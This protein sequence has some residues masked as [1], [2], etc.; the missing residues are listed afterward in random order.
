M[1]ESKRIEV[2]I[3]NQIAHVKLARPNKHNA[4]DM[5]MFDSIVKTIK[6]LKKDRSIRVVIL[7]GQ[8]PDFCTGL[9]VKS[10]MKSVKGPLKLLLKST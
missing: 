8:G 5:L 7:S 2:E 1:I 6:M 10:V 3:I 9:D 4:L